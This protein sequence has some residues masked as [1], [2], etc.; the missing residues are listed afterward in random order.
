MHLEDCNAGLEGTEGI[1]QYFIV[2]VVE[3]GPQVRSGKG[4]GNMHLL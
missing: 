1:M 4:L 3:Q 2:V